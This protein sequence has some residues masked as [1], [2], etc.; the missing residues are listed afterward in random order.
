VTSPDEI[1]VI[2]LAAGKGKR[3]KSDLPKVMHEL[4]G[5]PI[6]RHVTDNLDSLGLARKVLVVGV[7][8][9]L[10]MAEF[11]GS[12]YEFA[13]QQKQLGTGDAVRAAEQ[14]FADSEGD[15][16]IMLGDVP[17]LRRES[18]AELIDK[19]RESDAAATVLTCT[20]DDAGGYGRIIRDEEGWVKRIVEHAD[21]T[22]E[23][24]QVNEINTGIMIFKAAAL[25][26]TLQRIGCDNAQ[27]EYYLT[28]AF[29]LLLDGDQRSAAVMLADYREGLG[30]NSLAQLD[31]L[32]GLVDRR[33]NIDKQLGEP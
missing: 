13:V 21:A 32:H 5:K 23:E 16:L 24:R 29:K 4:A 1:I 28:D 19:H 11:E 8:R 7:G 22:D 18:L 2:I 3:M 20:P 26:D 15:V 6:I 10:I 33:I 31:A 30:V 25:R 12:D 27:G 17:L 14:Y 9:E